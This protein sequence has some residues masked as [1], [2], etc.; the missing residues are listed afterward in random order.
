M[1]EEE[2]AISQ[3][4][5]PRNGWRGEAVAHAEATQAGLDMMHRFCEGPTATSTAT[6]CEA[7]FLVSTSL[8]Q[9]EKSPCAR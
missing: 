1:S 8:R 6:D 4:F 9:E 2:P 7:S 3:G 5:E